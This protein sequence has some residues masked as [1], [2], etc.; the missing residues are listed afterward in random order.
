M[1]D[2]LEDWLSCLKR[3]IILLILLFFPRLCSVGLG[4]ATE[5]GIKFAGVAEKRIGWSELFWKNKFHSPD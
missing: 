1:E 5:F 4:K 3:H 2:S